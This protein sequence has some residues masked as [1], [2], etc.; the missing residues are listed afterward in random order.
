M[1]PYK[2]TIFAILVFAFLSAFFV[3]PYMNAA[4]A[5]VMALI[6]PMFGKAFLA[7]IGIV[8]TLCWLLKKSE[9]YELA[10]NPIDRTGY[11]ELEPQTQDPI[12]AYEKKN[13]GVT[14][15]EP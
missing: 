12:L 14:I 8:G 3:W 10:K 6:M 13:D 1:N 5:P 11:Q 9:A 4:S 7:A 2:F 15:Y